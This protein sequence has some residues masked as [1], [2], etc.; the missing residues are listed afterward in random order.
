MQNIPKVDFV[1]DQER[2]YSQYILYVKPNDAECKKVIDSMNHK[3]ISVI[4]VEDI[5]ISPPPSWLR[6]VPTLYSRRARVKTEG[7]SL[8]NHGLGL[9]RKQKVTSKVHTTSGESTLA[10]S[11]LFE[12]GMWLDVDDAEQRRWRTKK[13]LDARPG[14]SAPNA[15]QYLQQEN[16]YQKPQIQG[17]QNTGIK[18]TH[19][20]L[21]QFKAQRASVDQRFSNRNNQETHGGERQLQQERYDMRTEMDSNN[22]IEQYKAQ[23]ASFEQQVMTRNT[24]LHNPS[25]MR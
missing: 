12:D 6:G 11:G 24:Q 4:M 5:T 14:Q 18:P 9:M 13:S 20:V 8:I 15:D 2:E 22:A 16:Q 23:R 21:E 1:R 25:Y 3:G 17:M 10:S 7:V 19:A